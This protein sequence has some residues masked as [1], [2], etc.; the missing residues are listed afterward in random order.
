MITL[1]NPTSRSTICRTIRTIQ[2]ASI[3]VANGRSLICSLAG[4]NISTNRRIKNTSLAVSATFLSGTTS[5]QICLIS[6]VTSV[7]K[8]TST[9]ICN[10]AWLGLANRALATLCNVLPIAASV[11]TARTSYT[12][13]PVVARLTLVG[14]AWSIGHAIVTVSVTIASAARSFSCVTKPAITFHANRICLVRVIKVC[15]WGAA[16][17]AFLAYVNTRTRPR[18]AIAGITDLSCV[19]T[20]PA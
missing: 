6:Q 9:L 4:R 10:D 2:K 20:R 5:I 18:F 16:L 11:S 19:A 13:E 8:L 14:V 17:L 3:P 12:S 15:T 7:A 1:T